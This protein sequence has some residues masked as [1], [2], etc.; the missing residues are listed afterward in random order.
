MNITA[1]EFKNNHGDAYRA[2]YR[3]E[4]VIIN[5]DRFPDV[6]FELTARP[7][8]KVEADDIT[9]ACIDKLR[10]ENSP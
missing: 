8:V 7:R 5:S 2:A 10:G 9:K 1:T 3:G 4:T 6:M